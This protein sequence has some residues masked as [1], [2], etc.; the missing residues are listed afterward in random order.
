[1]NTENKLRLLRYEAIAELRLMQTKGL[2]NVKKKTSANRILITD[3]NVGNVFTDEN[4]FQNRF[5]AFSEDSKDRIIRAVEAGT[6]DWAK[7]DPIIV[8]RD[9]LKQKFFV[10]SGHSRL[11]AFKEL[12]KTS[13]DFSEIPV[14]IF[15]G[16][17]EQAIDTALMSNTLATKE[18][19]I[20]RAIYWAN[21]RKRCEIKNNIVAGLGATNV[22]EKEIELELKDAEGK[23]ANYILNLSYL[24]PSGFLMDNLL[25]MGTE[26]DNESA[27]TMRTI[28]NW[29]GE[30]R[31]FNK[32]ISNEQESEI[33]KFLLNG[34]YGNK[35][36]QFR[37]KATFN[38]R[39]KFS[40]DKWK[41]AGADS[42]RPLN[43]ANTLSKSSFEQEFDSRLE[44]AKVELAKAT[45]EHEE[46]YK[47]YL[48]ALINEDITQERM[49][50]LMKPLT[51]AVKHASERIN[52]IRGT[53]SDVMQA[54]RNQTSLFGTMSDDNY[55]DAYNEIEI[56]WSEYYRSA[57]LR[58]KFKNLDILLVDVKI[59]NI[60]DC[61]V[62]MSRIKG[63][64]EGV[65][66]DNWMKERERILLY[67]KNNPLLKILKKK[68]DVDKYVYDK[69]Y[70]ALLDEF[71]GKQAS[72]F[73]L[74][75]GLEYDN[76]ELGEMLGEIKSK[77]IIQGWN[78]KVKELLKENNKAI[79]KA[80]VEAQKA[81]DYIMGGNSLENFDPETWKPSSVVQ[82]STPTPTLPD[83]MKRLHLA[84]IEAKIRLQKMKTDLSGYDKLDE[85]DKTVYRARFVLKPELRKTLLHLVVASWVRKFKTQLHYKVK[86]KNIKCQLK[87]K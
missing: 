38:E 50:E 60:I 55:W 63:V 66:A 45:L 27:N 48:Q 54:V 18:T 86:T 20:E 23:N 83:K 39:L 22:C 70:K 14:K 49:D 5:N 34:G 41:F 25:R 72:L 56:Y 33:A 59:S 74:F 40:F 71:E 73:G 36:G 52:Q 87:N 31:R 61:E 30:A 28:A 77:T 8:W 11:A 53:K 80:A 57:S 43:L 21:R 64:E 58:L 69:I 1:M 6:F 68:R 2:K 67:V 26:R 85:I 65:C 9:P 24:N 32:E 82:T 19:D 7:F 76:S 3:M 13:H 81:R 62:Y 79:F 46:K 16:T 42:N 10:L 35:A 44:N 15:K 47:K 4:R 75:Y 51:Y 29:I 84:E 17:E 78:K 37:N 12:S